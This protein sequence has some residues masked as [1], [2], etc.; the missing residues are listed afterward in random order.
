[1]ATLADMGEHGVDVASSMRVG[2]LADEAAEEDAIDPVLPHPPEMQ[3]DR[4]LAVGAVEPGRRAVGHLEAGDLAQVPRVVLREVGPHVDREPA[5]V[6]S[7]QPLAP[8]DEAEIR[9]VAGRVEPPLIA[10]EDLA[11]ER[12]GIDVGASGTG[13]RAEPRL[14]GSRGEGLGRVRARLE[15][16]QESQEYQD[17]SR[18]DS[19]HPRPPFFKDYFLESA[20]QMARIV[21]SWPNPSGTDGPGVLA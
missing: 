17:R 2:G 21:S 7:V 6:G 16:K 20:A 13:V 3:E 8:M 14:V 9:A 19:H 1:M 11:V 15:E 4:A 10:A 18:V 12:R 5:A